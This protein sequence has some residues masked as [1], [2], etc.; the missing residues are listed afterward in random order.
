MTGCWGMSHPGEPLSSLVCLGPF[1]VAR[2]ALLDSTALLGDPLPRQ[3]WLPGWA[4]WSSGLCS[5]LTLTKSFEG[6]TLLRILHRLISARPGA[7][8]QLRPSALF[9]RAVPV[10]SFVTCVT[11]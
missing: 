11:F 10:L 4:S 2:P 6:A 5:N 9:L 1:E 7:L 3:T 8:C